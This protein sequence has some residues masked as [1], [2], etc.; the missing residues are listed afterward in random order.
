MAF[1]VCLLLLGWSAPAWAFC[2]VS[3]TSVMFGIYWG[4]A[5]LSTTGSVS[6]NCGPG[7]KI[8]PEV[9]LDKGKKLAGGFAVRKMKS[10]SNK[11]VYNL[12]TDATHTTVWGDGT[13]VSVTQFGRNLTIY[14]YMPAAQTV[15]PATYSDTVLVTASW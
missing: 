15:P 8:I 4:N 1:G 12:Y 7:S 3:T 2:S 14:G 11:L 6:V 9:Q 13:G 10:G 5:P